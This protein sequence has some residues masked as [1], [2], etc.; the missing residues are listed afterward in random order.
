M[1]D[2][3]REMNRNKMKKNINKKRILTSSG[4]K[5]SVHRHIYEAGLVFPNFVLSLPYLIRK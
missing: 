3:K 5:I 1:S 2:R 4:A